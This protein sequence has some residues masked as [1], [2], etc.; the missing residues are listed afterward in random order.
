MKKSFKYLFVFLIVVLLGFSVWHFTDSATF[1]ANGKAVDIGFSD[2]WQLRT[3][4]AINNAAGYEYRCGFS[5]D[6]SVEMGG[7]T[8][9]LAQ[10][11]CGSVYVKELDL[12]YEI[13]SER[14][15]RLTATLDKYLSM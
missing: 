2:S 9:C 6:Y 15:A 11:D 1:N 5:P 12:Y 8:Y 7:L 10:D 14:H 13:S 4:L 3:S